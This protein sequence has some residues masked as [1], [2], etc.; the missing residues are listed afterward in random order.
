M[1]QLVGHLPAGKTRVNSAIRAQVSATWFPPKDL[2]RKNSLFYS[3]GTL[4]GGEGERQAK[5]SSV[6]VVMRQLN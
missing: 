3:L 4:R 6:T 2:G 1:Q 5:F